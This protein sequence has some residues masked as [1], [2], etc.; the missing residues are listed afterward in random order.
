[1]SSVRG[2][3]GFWPFPLLNFIMSMAGKTGQRNMPMLQTPS[4]S[5][6]VVNS[7][8][9]TWTDWKGRTRNMTIRREVKEK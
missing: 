1:M 8:D 9:I 6:A 5:P 7:E 3:F 4:R 2:P